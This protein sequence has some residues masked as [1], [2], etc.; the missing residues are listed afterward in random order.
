[1]D[2]R[3]ILAYSIDKNFGGAINQAVQ[4]IQN[5]DAWVVLLDGDSMF[6]T[7]DYGVRIHDALALEGD[8]YG[9]LGCYTNRLNGL[10]QLH[11][12][13][14]SDDFDVRNHHKIALSYTAVGIKETNK[15]IAGMF[16]CFQKKTWR[17]VGKFKENDLAFDTLFSRAVRARGMKLGLIKNLYLFHLYRPLS[18]RPTTSIKHLL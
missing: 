14:I 17:M 5:D 10:H 8:K 9:L 11:N 6:L 7:P 15:S 3:Y 2:I 18:D 4:D 16:M 12:H 1:M 13:R